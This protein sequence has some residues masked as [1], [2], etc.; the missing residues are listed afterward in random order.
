MKKL[1]AV[2]MLTFTVFTHVGAE[3][4]EGQ[5][6]QVRPGRIMTTSLEINTT[7]IDV[8]TTATMHPSWDA[9]EDGINDCEKDGTCDHTTDYTQAK[10]EMKVCT[11]DYRPVCAA[12]KVQCVKAP[13]NPIP[14]TFSNKCMAGENEI[15][16]Q[17][18]CNSLVDSQKFSD[19]FKFD[20]Q[21][22]A[23]LEKLSTTTLEKMV[24]ELN[25]R[26]SA[27]EKSRIAVFVQTQRITKLMYVKSLVEV[28]LESR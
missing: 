2:I 15:L 1:F 4:I 9:D 24:I 12:V 6:N 13:C 16:Y 18:K 28:E 5:E 14:Q 10:P 17:G 3:Y 23:R 25:Q 26:I 11:M 21:I 22:N 19:Y 27:V 7:S 20:S 8:E